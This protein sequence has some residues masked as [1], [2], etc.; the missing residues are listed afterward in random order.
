M[1]GLWE[2]D[3]RVYASLPKSIHDETLQLLCKEKTTETHRSSSVE[4]SVLSVCRSDGGG[5]R[6]E[7]VVV[8]ALFG[9]RRFGVERR[10]V[11]RED[12]VNGGGCGILLHEARRIHLWL[13]NLKEGRGGDSWVIRSIDVWVRRVRWWVFGSPNRFRPP[14]SEIVQESAS[15]PE[16]FY[17]RNTFGK[18]I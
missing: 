4:A 14:C 12:L 18:T 8:S 10:Y 3:I 15:I 16:Q 7:G 9:G 2:F 6:A 13:R 5:V 17:A 1:A 11:V